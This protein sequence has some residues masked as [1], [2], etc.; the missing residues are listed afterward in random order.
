MLVGL[1]KDGTYTVLKDDEG[2]YNHRSR[3]EYCVVDCSSFAKGPIH[4]IVRSKDI[5][6]IPEELKVDITLNMLNPECGR[7]NIHGLK[8]EYEIDSLVTLYSVITNLYQYDLYNMYMNELGYELEM[9]EEIIVEEIK[10]YYKKNEKSNTLVF[11]YYYDAPCNFLDRFLKSVHMNVYTSKAFKSYK[12][13]I[14][15]KSGVYYF[16]DEVPDTAKYV[17]IY[18]TDSQSFYLMTYKKFLRF[19]KVS[20]IEISIGSK[21]V[22]TEEEC[23]QHVFGVGSTTDRYEIILVIP[24]YIL[25]YTQLATPNILVFT[26]VVM[27]GHQ[28]LISANSKEIKKGFS[29]FKIIDE[30][31]KI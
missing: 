15:D 28:Y 24:Q 26:S 19:Q 8:M 20:H 30:L 21:E 13:L 3:Y 2:L 22:E 23:Y 11:H 18:M 1:S 25:L 5:R 7:D 6:P 10:L 9:N 14:L 12:Y 29:L 16:D 27:N 4:T 31:T 17:G